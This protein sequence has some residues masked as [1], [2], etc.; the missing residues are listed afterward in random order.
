MQKAKEL[1][2]RA[3]DI[4]LKNLEPDHNFVAFSYQSLGDVHRER[5]DLELAKEYHTRALNIR[6]KKIWSLA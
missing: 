6:L 1:Y 5:G 2:E 4:Q 3:L